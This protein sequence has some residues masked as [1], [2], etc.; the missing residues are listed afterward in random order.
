MLD[1]LGFFRLLLW[2]GTE[3]FEME[4]KTSV[5]G[6]TGDREYISAR[7]IPCEGGSDGV[8]IER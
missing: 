2:E 5:A 6:E 1:D 8:S 3:P 4:E 7:S